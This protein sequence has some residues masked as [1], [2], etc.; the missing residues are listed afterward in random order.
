MI[1]DRNFYIDIYLNSVLNVKRLQKC[2]S[3]F[4]YQL[5]KLINYLL[6]LVDKFATVITQAQTRGKSAR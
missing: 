5:Y 2:I 6:N 3:L 1:D 4:N